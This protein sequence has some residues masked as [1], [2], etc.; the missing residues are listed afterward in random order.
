MKL[1]LEEMDDFIPSLN[2]KCVPIKTNGAV[3]GNDEI[4]QLRTITGR[5]YRSAL[6]AFNNMKREVRR[7]MKQLPFTPLT[8]F[9]RDD[10]KILNEIKHSHNSSVGY[11]T[12]TNFSE[13]LGLEDFTM[14][15]ALN[16]VELSLQDK[17]NK[18]GFVQLHIF[19]VRLGFSPY[20]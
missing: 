14:S 11:A 17:I 3:I 8:I 2:L 7:Y 5:S 13:L 1:S 10:L 16:D 12:Q 19:N 6:H 15:L 4:L 9:F 20:E 18:Y